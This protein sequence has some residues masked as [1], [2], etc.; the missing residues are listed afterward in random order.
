MN[1]SFSRTQKDQYKGQAKFWGIPRTKNHLD[2]AC[3]KGPFIYKVTG[4]PPGVI[5]GGSLQKYLSIRGSEI[6][7]LKA[8]RG[9]NF[10]VV[11]EPIGLSVCKILY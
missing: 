4:G 6:K 7:I 5:Y 9:H 11:R 3:H 2:K 1:P 10:F 8:N